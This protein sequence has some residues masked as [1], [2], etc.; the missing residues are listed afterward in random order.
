MYL[1]KND[2]LDS[3]LLT[4]K[5]P[6]TCYYINM[7]GTNTGM[8]KHCYSYKIIHAFLLVYIYAKRA[9]WKNVHQNV[10]DS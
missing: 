7:W 4:W 5:M 2:S 3:Y 9:I 1:H 10:K 8:N 6:R